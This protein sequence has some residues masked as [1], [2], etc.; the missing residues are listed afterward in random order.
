[1][2]KPLGHIVTFY[3]Y[4]G[5]VGRTLAL[6]DV[7]VLLAQWGYRVL[8]VD[9]DLEAPGLDVYF[10]P[11]LP[12]LAKGGLTEMFAGYEEESRL[13][14]QSLAEVVPTPESSG[15]LQ[16]IRAGRNDDT[17]GARLQSLHWDSLYDRGVGRA[18][19]QMRDEWR[20]H[21]DFV[22]IDSRTGLS[23]ISGI[24]TIQMPS[25]IV[26]LF[27][28]NDQS[29]EGTLRVLRTAQEKQSRL[30]V[31]RATL[32]AVPVA[33]RVDNTEYEA[34]ERWMRSV[35]GAFSSFVEYWLEIKEHP[36]QVTADVDPIAAMLTALSVPYVP[37]WSYGEG[38]P[39][40]R[41]SPSDKFGVRHGHESLAGLL[42]GGLPDGLD[43]V[44][45]RE[46]TLLG[47]REGV[48]HTKGH[49]PTPSYGG[50][51]PQ[52][53]PGSWEI[54]QEGSVR[55]YGYV[56]Q[57]SPQVTIQRWLFSSDYVRPP[58]MHATFLRRPIQWSSLD[59]W[60]MFVRDRW[61]PGSEYA[62]A[63]STSYET[64]DEFRRPDQQLDG[65][66]AV[67]RIGLRE[68]ADIFTIEDDEDSNRLIEHWVLFDTY[69]PEAAGG[70]LVEKPKQGVPGLN[71]FRA[72]WR[73]EW[74]SGF[75]YVTTDVRYFSA[76]P[77][78][79]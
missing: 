43:I 6:A 74:Q 16:L 56:I 40:L 31:D 42:A 54:V 17:Y 25:I 3:S 78:R 69:D 4:K 73:S 24:C 9:W 61:G 38:L 29:M 37:F 21:F 76:L 2:G 67:A 49:R 19:E 48:Q 75:T 32:L 1:M 8:C 10:R 14:W 18:L 45:H 33:T 7:S 47:L 15:R 50:L 63:I 41:D 27:T 35:V 44:S 11:W 23:D 79:L 64:I 46:Q 13:D 68:V 55:G 39:V 58:K 70:I 12:R 51:K 66:A 28:L 52:L 53:N 5:G 57:E 36:D 65:N 77:A 62:L 60:T 71:E 22:L 34:R 59:D 20:Q 26:A 30:P 72:M